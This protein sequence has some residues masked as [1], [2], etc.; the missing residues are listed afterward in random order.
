M[1]LKLEGQILTGGEITSV[2]GLT[3]IL[4]ADK[5]FKLNN[6]VY[7]FDKWGN[8]STSL[9]YLFTVPNQD[10][11]IIAHFISEEL[12]SG[13]GLNLKFY[14]N[15]E[16][17]D[18]D[19]PDLTLPKGTVNFNWGQSSP[20]SIPNDH[21]FARF[22]GWIKPL[23]TDEYT[24]YATGDDGFNLWVD[25]Q[26]IIHDWTNHGRITFEG[27]IHLESGRLYPIKLEYFELG[28]DASIDLAWSNNRLPI[29]IIPQQQ[30]YSSNIT[31]STSSGINNSIYFFPNPS[32][33]WVTIS[34]KHLP[35]KS[36]SIY[37]LSG[38][39]ITSYNNIGDN[40]KIDI[41]YLKE[42]AYIIE[43]NYENKSFRD[44]LFKK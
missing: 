23:F 15:K 30:L 39:L 21:F 2:A 37:S 13:D 40:S 18:T 24:F 44:I 34:S 43:L 10:T 27:K 32:N 3:R 20:E 36:V 28:G 9:Y 16:N 6:S 17:F 33:D 5:S 11:T 7:T 26:H 25:G 8:S 19:Q 41:N 35:C 38:R 1:P 22:E 31:T 42:G 29:E 4:S 12:G 14:K